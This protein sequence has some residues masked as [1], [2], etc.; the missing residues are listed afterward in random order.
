M[1]FYDNHYYHIN[2]ITLSIVGQWP[3]QSRLKSN[4][5]FTITVLFVF[6]LAALQ[7]WGLVAGI[8][9]LNIVME[10]VPA[11]LYISFC[12]KRIKSFYKYKPNDFFEVQMKELLEHVEKTWKIMHL[13]P[14][15]KILRLYAEESRTS[16]V[17][18]LI[19]LYSVWIL[20]CVTPIAINRIYLLLPTNKTY[21]AR[22]LYRIEHVLDIEKYYN[23]LMLHGFIGI[24]YTVSVPIAVDCLFVLCTQHVCALFKCIKYNIEL[25]RGSDFVLLNPNIA[26]DEAYHDLINCIKLYKYALKLVLLLDTFCIV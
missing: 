5:M 21:S 26:D 9:D 23:L 25:I 15:S 4:M 24:F 12:A 11:F 22:F 6:T 20:Y 2:K 16:T 18:Y 17:R 3:F 13:R 19:A 14:E 10:N 8:M 7:L 1:S